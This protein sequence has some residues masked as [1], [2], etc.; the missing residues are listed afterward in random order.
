MSTLK[1]PIAFTGNR[2]L[3]GE[4]VWLG[5]NG[6][7]VDN[8]DLALVARSAETL[9]TASAQAA[10]ADADN[11]VVEPYQ[12]DVALEDGVVTPVKFRER[13][14]A[15]GPTVRMDLGKQALTTAHA[16]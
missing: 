1:K 4:T 9:A 14:R 8:I 13:I 11:H 5:Q 16:A 7:W 12:I 2:L 10:Q 3:D 6:I 15:S